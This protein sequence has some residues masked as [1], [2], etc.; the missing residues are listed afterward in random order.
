V[1]PFLDA[2]SNDTRAALLGNA[3]TLVASAWPERLRRSRRVIIPVGAHL[4]FRAVHVSM[5]GAAVASIPRRRPF[6]ETLGLRQTPAA[7]VLRCA[8][9]T[10]PRT[11]GM[12]RRGK[13]AQGRQLSALQRTRQE[14]KE[15]LPCRQGVR[16]ALDDPEEALFGPELLLRENVEPAE[17]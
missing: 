15:L 7:T 9:A 4:T 1:T 6:W 14:S 8:G 13:L 10:R 12:S 2:L 3:K 17:I 16:H 5:V 11:I